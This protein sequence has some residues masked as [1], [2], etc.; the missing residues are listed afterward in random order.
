MKTG[1]NLKTDALSSPKSTVQPSDPPEA[2]QAPSAAAPLSLYDDNLSFEQ[3]VLDTASVGILVYRTSG[4]CISANAASARIVG[5]SREQLLQQNFLQLDSWKRSGLLDAAKAALATHTEQQKET[6]HVTTFGKEVWLSCRFVTFCH[7]SEPHLLLT[8][9]DISQHKLREKEIERM[10]RLYAALSQINECIVKVESREQLFTEICKIIVEHG[11]FKMTWIAWLNPQDPEVKVAARHGDECGY[12]DKVRIFADD[13]PEGR[14]PAGIALREGRTYVCNDF[15]TDPVTQ[16]WREAAAQSHFASGISVPIRLGGGICAAL[17]VYASEKNFF[18]KPEVALMEEASLDI[19]F[20]LAHLEQEH[21]RK[22]VEEENRQL[23]VAIDQSAESIVFTDLMGTILYVNQGFEKTTGYN[24]QEALGQKPSLLKS[25]QQP[26]E[27]YTQLWDTLHRGEVWTGRFINL[28]KNG[29]RFEEDATITPI[30]GR[31]GKITSFVAVK[32]DITRE[33]QLERQIIETQKLDAIGQL[34]GGV[35][36]DYNNILAATLIQLGLL[37]TDPGLSPHV[38]EALVSLKKNADRAAKL[39][40]QLLMFSRRE[41]M[42]KK[43]LELNA[44]VEDELK[45]LHRLLGEHIDLMIRGHSSEAWIEADSGM[46]EQVLMNLC[47]NARDAMPQGGRLTVGVTPV[48]LAVEQ[49]I[50]AEARPGDFICLSV[51]DTGCGMSTETI[52]RI[53]EPFFTTKEIGKGTGLGLATVYGIVKQHQGWIEIASEPGKGSVFRVYLPASKSAPSASSHPHRPKII[54][55]TGTILLVEDEETVRDS[56]S[57]CLKHV[58]YQ[59][60]EAAS[61]REA[62]QKWSSRLDEIDL[63]FTDMVMPGGINGLEL[64]ESLLKSKPSLPVIITSGYNNEMVQTILNNR[65]G[66]RFLHKPYDLS[67]LTTTIRQSLSRPQ[68]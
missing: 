7:D 50:H 8:I 3:T 55:G 43:P 39:T 35:A 21:K 59:V 1:R 10:N 16:P 38:R 58:G 34:A 53:F 30:R 20:A 68:P 17:M 46:M 51:A 44:L 45:M 42:Q 5:I 28:R 64:A 49:I 26:T 66:F 56:M 65:P 40:R 12:L 33:V 23:I 36:H 52:S 67:L 63:L 41:A 31:T 54:P 47:L 15:A 29:T 48:N 57:Q 19:S 4:Q 14:G 22:L 18:G 60:F 13:R 62:L 32:R 61:G 24:R 11:R 2:V 9:N 6:N 37:M 27:F 25:G